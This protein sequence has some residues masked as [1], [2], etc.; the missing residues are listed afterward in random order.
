[1]SMPPP[2][3]ARPSTARRLRRVGAV[4]AL[5][6]VLAA[7]VLVLLG[8]FWGAQ[9]ADYASSAAERRGVRYLGP[10]TG[11][12]DAVTRQQS[13][14]VRRQSVDAEAVRRSVAA[15]DEVDRLVGRDLATTERWTRLRQQVVDLT[16]RTFAG[17]DAALTAYSEVVDT[18]LAL[19][20]KAGD[21]SNLIL[22]PQLDVYYV[23]NTALLR[24]PEVLVASGRYSDLLQVAAALK[25]ASRPQRLAALSTARSRVLTA[26]DDLGAGLEKAFDIT[27][28]D[29]LGPAMLRPLDDFRTAVDGLAP[30]TSPLQAGSP[31]LD[32]V[33]AGARQDT[34]ARAAMDLDR[35]ALAQLDDLV[36]TRLGTITRQLVV[37][38]LTGA[39]GL[40][41][42][43]GA[44]FWLRPV[45]RHD[46]PPAP[47]ERP[48]GARHAGRAESVDAHELVASSGVAVSTRRGGARAAR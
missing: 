4:A 14:A 21:T 40:L 6:T 2:R 19:V 32:P 29:R 44:A 23:M 27:R 46:P 30:R 11:L 12:L 18:T 41:V 36:G 33:D 16:D 38:A 8:Q 24:L 17:A 15:V 31:H 26:A 20:R 45:R 39:L 22:D 3:P 28:S 13:A 42:A 1:M 43:V 47:V 7:P 5:A 35:A 48:A 37:A 34:L 25:D 10:L 9:S